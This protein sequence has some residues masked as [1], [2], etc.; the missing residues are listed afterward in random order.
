[1]TGR[2]RSGGATVQR[3]AKQE[4]AHQHAGCPLSHLCAE[5]AISGAFRP[6][7]VNRCPFGVQPVYHMKLRQGESCLI[8]SV[9]GCDSRSRSSMALFGVQNGEFWLRTVPYFDVVQR[10]VAPRGNCQ[11][12]TA[13]SCFGSSHNFSPQDLHIRERRFRY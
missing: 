11:L 13:V 6:H 3:C 9:P 7:D 1:M 2:L 10:A 5:A 4:H 8:W 12:L